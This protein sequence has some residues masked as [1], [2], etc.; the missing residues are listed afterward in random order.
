VLVRSSPT[1]AMV[2]IDGVWSGRTPHTKR[3]LRFG[4]HTVRVVLEGYEP[5]NRTI[6]L[7]A[8]NPAEEMMFELTRA[9]AREPAPAAEAPA[10]RAPSTAA[11]ALSISS[12]P[13]GARVLV[14][15]RAVGT[16]PMKLAGVTPGAHRVRIELAGYR[17]WTTTVQ[18]GRTG[19]ARVAASLVAQ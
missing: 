17:P 4:R 11:G 15:G 5:I 14:D 13:L 19:E 18:V 7:S 3:D 10:P 6:T 12:R 8:G 9:A 1:N 16:T 2:V